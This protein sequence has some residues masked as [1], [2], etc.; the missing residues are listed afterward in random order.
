MITESRIRSE[1]TLIVRWE[2]T[3]KRWVAALND[4]SDVEVVAFADEDMQEAV[5]NAMLA[6][7]RE[8]EARMMKQETNNQEVA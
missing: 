4:G 1:Y 7:D 3:S 2:H 5:D 6:W 8:V